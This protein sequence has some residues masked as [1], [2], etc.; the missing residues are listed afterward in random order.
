M[1]R[2]ILLVRENRRRL[3]GGK[4]RGV[5][6]TRQKTKFGNG[7]HRRSIIYHNLL[8]Y[9]KQ[10]TETRFHNLS[11][12]NTICLL[13]SG[14]IPP[15]KRGQPP[16]SS[17]RG[18]KP[19]SYKSKKR[20][21]QKEGDGTSTSSTDPEVVVIT[22]DA[23]TAA[24][25][26]VFEPVTAIPEESLKS[27][28]EPLLSQRSRRVAIAYVFDSKYECA[29]DTNDNPWSGVGGIMARQRRILNK[30]WRML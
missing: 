8:Y 19:C 23:S 29:E 4:W 7:R 14:E 13:L 11:V 10:I 25:D 20:R 3:R 27:I 15:R 5:P 26:D 9:H 21:Q 12:V 6:F 16:K 2:N 28:E 17:G 1:P 18:K 22:E 24:K 30:S